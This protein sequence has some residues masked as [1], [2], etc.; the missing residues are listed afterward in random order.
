MI[1]TDAV[2]SNIK[3]NNDTGFRERISTREQLEKAI[4]ERGGAFIGVDFKGTDDCYLDFRGMNLGKLYL[5]DVRLENCD[6]SR[7][8]MKGTSIVR[9]V[10]K[11]V[12]FSGADLSE[13]SM[14]RSQATDITMIGTTLDSATFGACKIAAWV[15]ADASLHNG[16]IYGCTIRNGSFER[17]DLSGLEI[18]GGIFE[19]LNFGEAL[20][21]EPGSTCGTTFRNVSWR[22]A[23][24]NLICKD[25]VFEG[26]DFSHS[27]LK[28]SSFMRCTFK[29]PIE[30]E[31][32]VGFSN[33][34]QCTLDNVN[35]LPIAR[36]P[37]MIPKDEFYKKEEARFME[38]EYA[39]K[40]VFEWRKSHPDDRYPYLCVNLAYYKKN[41]D[42]FDT[43]MRRHLREK[44]LTFAESPM[45]Q[46]EESRV[47]LK[48]IF[49]LD[50][51]L[52][53]AESNRFRANSLDTA[54]SESPA[55][56]QPP[57]TVISIGDGQDNNVNSF[58]LRA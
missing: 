7:A 21:G 55:E 17:V 53:A 50:D 18:D 20:A 42:W 14:Y 45:L 46:D 15:V 30:L 26:A 29:A 37:D 39:W 54:D 41:I 4:K 56:N 32:C 34:S 9:S 10:L 6:F 35:L 57:A 23:Q 40:K 51:A 1:R 44:I 48:E 12:D 16:K 11:G 49:T 58:H 5:S 38:R 36:M 8:K 22:S 19:D 33:L 28:N 31:Q 52:T 3:Q 27:N 25:T 2:K 13:F 24:V 47:L 43:E